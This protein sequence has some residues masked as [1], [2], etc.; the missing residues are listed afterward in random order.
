[1]LKQNAVLFLR[2]FSVSAFIGLA[3]LLILELAQLVLRYDDGLTHSLV[4]FVFYVIGIFVN[5]LMQKKLVFNASN[6]PWKSFLIYNMSSAVL[7]SALSGYLYSNSTMTELFAP[8][9]EAVSTALA[10]LLI[11]P[12]TFIVFKKIFKVS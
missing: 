8:F 6:S 1:V 7:V 9:N 10:L 5:Y 2:I 3:Y 4:A 11:S 12:I